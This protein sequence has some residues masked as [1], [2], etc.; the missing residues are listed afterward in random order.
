M[1]RTLEEIVVDLLQ[2]FFQNY[3]TGRFRM[4]SVITNIYKKET[5]RPSFMELFTATETF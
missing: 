1:E 4:F 3:Y 2:A 5:K